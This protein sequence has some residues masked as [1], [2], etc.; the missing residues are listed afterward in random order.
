MAQLADPAPWGRSTADTVFLEIVVADGVLPPNSD[1]SHPVWIAPTSVK[2]EPQPPCGYMVSLARLHEWGF[3]VPTGRFIRSH[4]H[5]YKVELHNFSP[6]SIS[7]AAVFVAVCEDYL[8]VEVHWELWMHLFCEEL[9]TEHVQQGPRRAARVGGLTLQVRENRRDLYI[10]CKM[11]MNNREWSRWWFYLRN[12]GKRLPA[13]TG[14]VLR[15]KLDVWGYGVS[16][17]KRQAKLGVFTD[18]L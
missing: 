12:N 5:H 16:P 17:P 8:G 4:C 1:A 6:N 7:Q 13:Y 2:R 14:K 11:T 10:P 9:Y 18:A 15:D 3:G